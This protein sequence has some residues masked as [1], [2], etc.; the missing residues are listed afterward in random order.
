[1]CGRLVSRQPQTRKSWTLRAPT[2]PARLAVLLANQLELVTA[3]LETGAVAVI[4]GSRVCV[5]ELPI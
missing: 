2:E 3:F 1:M 5:R 4:S